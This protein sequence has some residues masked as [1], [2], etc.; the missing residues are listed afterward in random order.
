MQQKY[1]AAI[2]E[3]DDDAQ[4]PLSLQL[5]ADAQNKAGQTAEAQKTLTTLAAIND[6]RVETAFAVP[7]ARTALKANPGTTAQAT[8]FHIHP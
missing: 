4:N 7:P 5:L 6:E 1:D 2:Q 3:L 8:P